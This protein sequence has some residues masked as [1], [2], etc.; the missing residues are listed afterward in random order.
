MR[1]GDGGERPGHHHAARQH[2]PVPGRP[3]AGQQAERQLDQAPDQHRNGDQQPDLGVAQAEVGADQRERGAL[4]PVGKLID[5]LDRQCH[6]EGGSA[7]EASAATKPARPATR[8]R[9]RSAES[10]TDQHRIGPI[11]SAPPRSPGT[12]APRQP[13]HRLPHLRAGTD[14][15]VVSNFA[16]IPMRQTRTALRP[17]NGCKP[18][19]LSRCRHG[20]TPRGARPSTARRRR[21]GGASQD[22]TAAGA[23]SR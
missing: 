17:P 11:V 13:R 16:R 12:H 1:R 2:Q 3:L 9:A 15:G 21:P 6:G 10:V 20:P 22:M 19:P 5:E 4:R 8:P 7:K 18:V 23:A 14:L